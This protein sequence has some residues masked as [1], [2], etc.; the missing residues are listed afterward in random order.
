MFSP[1]FDRFWQKETSKVVYL[2]KV[3]IKKEGIFLQIWFKV[4]VGDGAGIQLLNN[5]TSNNFYQVWAKTGLYGH[6][7]IR[8]MK[9]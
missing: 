6:I 8:I 9:K 2:K 5:P 1:K 7:P 3:E 4:L